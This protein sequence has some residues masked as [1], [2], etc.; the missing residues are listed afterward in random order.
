M[1]PQVVDAD[2]ANEDHPIAIH[3]LEPEQNVKNAAPYKA[4]TREAFQSTVKRLACHKQFLLARTDQV[5][6][7][8][9]RVSLYSWSD[10][11]DPLR[12]P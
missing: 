7:R 10:T 12:P 11:L 3:G 4:G 5:W 6:R 2:A 9:E 8:C 1:A